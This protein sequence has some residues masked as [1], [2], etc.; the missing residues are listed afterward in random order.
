MRLT[1]FRLTAG[2]VHT[3][4]STDIDGT[5]ISEEKLNE[6]QQ[7]MLGASQDLNTEVYPSNTDDED[8][9]ASP[10][11]DEQATQKD[12]SR[13]FEEEQ[14]NQIIVR[15]NRRNRMIFAFDL[16]TSTTD[17]QKHCAGMATK[18]AILL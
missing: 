9:E 3:F 14:R 7:P 1:R 8:A 2:G 5:N 16:V 10:E 17:S 15:H 18:R 12:S 13:D 6:Q 11:E 4:S